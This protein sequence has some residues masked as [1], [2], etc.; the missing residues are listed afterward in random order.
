L[1]LLSSGFSRRTWAEQAADTYKNNGRVRHESIQ[2]TMGPLFNIQ[3]HSYQSCEIKDRNNT[4]YD[5]NSVGGLDHYQIHIFRNTEIIGGKPVEVIE[6]KDL[7]PDAITQD[8]SFI[9]H[10]ETS[11]ELC[12]DNFL[13]GIN[14]RSSL[15]EQKLTIDILTASYLIIVK[16]REGKFPCVKAPIS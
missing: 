1:N 13:K 2:L 6:G 15:I 5:H 8:A 9:G 12:L 10:N 7:F 16:K 3:V 14:N 4:A 11:R